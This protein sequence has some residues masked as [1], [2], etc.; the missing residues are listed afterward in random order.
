VRYAVN[1]PNFGPY[2]DPRTV[3]ELAADAEASGW[4][5]LFVWD[6]VTFI[7]ALNLE[8]G[9]PWIIL[10]AAALATER[11][12]LGTMVTPVPRRRPSKLARETVTLDR[13]SGGRLVLGV[14]LGAPPEDEYGSFGEAGDPGTLAARLDEGLEV[15]AGLWSGRPFS[16]SGRHYRVTDVAFHPT[17]VQQPRIPVWVGGTWPGTGPFRRAARWDGVV[18]MKLTEEPEPLTPAELA[19]VVEAVRAHRPGPEPF[20]VVA[21]GETTGEDR[22]ADRDLVGA[23]AAAGATWWSEWLHPLRGDLDTTRTR[24]LQGPPRVEPSGGD[25][26]GCG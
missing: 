10:T 18:P 23:L 24:V 11:L 19:G 9:D 4:D 5:G 20:D 14:G 1:L 3:A 16:F 22:P 15:L 6:H 17:P 8:I 12:R 2:A 21:G 26:L 25:G 7:K 13:L